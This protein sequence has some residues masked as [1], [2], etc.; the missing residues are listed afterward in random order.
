LS[1]KC[2]ALVIAAPASG[3]GKTTVTATLARYYRN[4]G[5]QVRVFKAG[6][7]FLDPMILEQ[8]SGH[9][10]YQLDLWMVGEQHCRQLLSD[11]AELAD[12]ILIEGVMGL[13]DGEPSTADLAATFGI[14]VLAVIDAS[15]MAQT[16]AALAFGLTHYR[17]DIPVTGVFANRIGS[18]RH[19][20]MLVDA[21]PDDLGCYG[22]LAR[23][24]DFTIPSRHLGLVQAEEI[25]DLDQG[26]DLLA[27]QIII[28]SGQNLPTVS[29]ALTDKKDLKKSLKGI[30]IA[31]ACDA[32]FSFIYQANLDL[33]KELGAELT[34]FSPLSDNNLPDADSLY[35]PGGYPELH[36][37]TLSNNIQMKLAITKHYDAGKPIVAECGG[38]L[39][40]T[41]S[42]KN[43][44]GHQAD[45]IGLLTGHTV[46]QSR[47]SALAIQ[48][49]SFNNKKL[50]G[51]TYHHSMFET[52]LSAIAYA[53]N[54]NANH[55][56]E[57][58]YQS[59]RLT[60]SYIHFYFPSNP[61]AIIE[62]FLP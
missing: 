18:D 44:E 34:F 33:L 42:L 32:A 6:P 7:D 60:A 58:V 55:T 59:A 30:K 37:D 57:A 4:Q 36:I 31:I 15:A 8:A 35:L 26:L 46:M 1:H 24:T 27:E 2:A 13:F 52:S 25:A 53:N 48:E 40:L 56:N 9:A 11:A 21:L 62:L 43:K 14:P 22:A 45:M 61:D 51:H 28:E 3:Q 16:F 23:Q 5:K 19:Y 47:L 10:V 29:F 50:R 39:Y 12:L 20:Q 54:P 41:E 17:Q 49:V 38:M